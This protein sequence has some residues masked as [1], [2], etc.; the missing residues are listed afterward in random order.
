MEKILLLEDDAANLQGITDVLRS[1][2]YSVVAA[3]TGLQ[4]IETIATCGPISLFITDMDLP[5]SSGTE[6]ALRLL[7]LDPNISVLFI[8]G[9]PMVWWTSRDVSNFKQFPP[10]SVDFIEKPF[11]ASQLLMGVRTMIGRSTQALVDKN[12]AARQGLLL[13][14]VVGRWFEP[15]Y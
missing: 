3:S 6:V 7:M 14:P 5:N 4:A 10:T 8:S 2:K 15:P 12:Q 1:D 11:S 9:T 13:K